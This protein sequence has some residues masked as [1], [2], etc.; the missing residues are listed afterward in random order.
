MVALGHRAV[1]R[2]RPRTGSFGALAG[3]VAGTVALAGPA[4]AFDSKGH[5][6]I[7]A[8]AY[9]TLVEGYQGQPPRPEVLRDLINDGALDRPWCFG[10]GGEL[11]SEC[12]KAP[13]ENP[14]LCWPEPKTD[15]P[16][17]FFRRQF[18]DPGQCFHYMG[19]LTDGLS[20]PIRGSAVPREL[21]TSAI[22]RCNNLLEILLRQIV[23][24]GGP[25][26]R[27]SGFGLYELL[28]AVE[29]SFSHAHSERTPEGE[30]LDYLR[31]WKPIEKIA[32][33]PTERSSKIPDTV[34][35]KWDDHRDKTYVVEGGEQACEERIDHPYDV[36]YAC[37][38][39]EGDR[40][41][42]AIVE[43]LVLVRD[44]RL[45]QRGA[46]PGTNTR[47]ETSPEWRHYLAKWFTPVRPCE[48][49]ECGVRQPPEPSPGKYAYLGLNTRFETP[50][51]F[52]ATAHGSVLR[53]AERL[54]PFLTLVSASLGYRYR[55]DGGSSGV[56]GLGAGLVLPVGLKAD[57]G[58]TAAELRTFFGGTGNG[59]ELLTRLLR[60]DYA[61]SDKLALS[62]EGP[63]VVNWVQPAVHWSV[64]LGLSYGLSSPRFV[65]GDT[66]L[67]HDDTTRREDAEWVPPP[68]PFGRLQAGSPRSASSPGSR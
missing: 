37:L 16:D 18:N 5:N 9:R 19:T 20:D 56:L 23:V 34:F 31:I 43:L 67:L 30:R 68:A 15:R 49:V 65:E 51:S 10:P 28:H 58:F 62:V 17:A 33:I 60:F 53:Y 66:L 41:R 55:T 45:A 46:S 27:Q 13:A 29:D 39:A 63:M 38:S 32:G 1:S 7:E 35:H 61:L 11:S 21:A 48:G 4:F 47:P 12:L 22:V 8:L 52:E 3:V 2:T 36:P 40:A 25:G 59:F 6:V 54:N 50:G 64:G 42:Q 26:T 24:D 57:I 44:L 14:L